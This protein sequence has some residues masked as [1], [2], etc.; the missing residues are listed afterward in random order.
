M[1]GGG[2]AQEPSAIRVFGILHLVL[3]GCGLLFGIWSLFTRQANSL[4]IDSSSPGYEAQLR[5]MEDMGWVSIM[6]G[7]FLIALAGLL[8]VAGIKL[9][10]SRPDGIAWS[11]RYA[12]ASIATKLI[13]LA[14]TVAV[15]LPAMQ[16]MVGGIMPPPAG[17]PPGSANAFSSVMKTA[18]SVG[19]VASPIISC[20]YPALAL[21]FLNRP[22]VREWA[23][24][25]R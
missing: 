24:R 21:F 22:R 6:T 25:P 12:W 5:Y 20:T 7:L 2:G 10:R 11:N 23:A 15:V 4:F 8:L 16:R 13:S 17:M 19:M 18:I 14:V 3:A 9:V 1:P